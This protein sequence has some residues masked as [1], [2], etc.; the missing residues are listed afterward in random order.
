MTEGKLFTEQ[1]ALLLEEIILNRRDIRGNRFID[2]PLTDACLD[3]LIDAAVH[4]PS[5]GFSQPWE[6][7]VIKDRTIKQQIKESFETAHVKESEFFKDEKQHEYI[8]LKM[9]GILEAPVNIAVF[10]KPSLEPVLGQ[11]SIKEAGI[12]SVVCAIQNM[13]LTARALNIGMCWVSI[14]NEKIVKKILNAPEENQ[15]IAYLC[16]GHVDKFL[17]QPELETLKWEKRKGKGN[18]IF[19]N[20][21]K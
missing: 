8:R 12:Y 13:W 21:Y 16:I 6:F 20:Q 1:E 17:T 2:E 19:F 15:L 3:R 10:Y 7:V 18:V 9:E 14:L 5:V 11:T 4:A